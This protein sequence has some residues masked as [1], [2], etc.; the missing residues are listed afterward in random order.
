[1]NNV[2]LTGR[3]TSDMAFATGKTTNY[4]RFTLAVQRDK[5]HADFIS[6]LAFGKTAEIIERY[7]HKGSKIGLTGRI[8]TGSYKNKDGKTV[9]TTEVV[10]TGVE[11]LEPKAEETEVTFQ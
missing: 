5:E 6:C 9:Y 7:T 3:L 2:T 11:F 8:Q 1:M 10:A 4:G